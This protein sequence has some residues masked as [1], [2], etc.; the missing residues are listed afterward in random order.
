MG[1]V[2]LLMVLGA[3]DVASAVRR[4][5]FGGTARVRVAASVA[6]ADPVASR[7]FG[8]WLLVE[9]VHR[10]LYRLD[11]ADR[12]LPELL[13]RPCNRQVRGRRW[14]C[15]LR[16]G[17]RFHDGRVL[18]AADVRAAFL[19]AGNPSI[20][21]VKVVGART[22]VLT[23]ARSM[24]SRELA[25]LLASPRMVVPRPGAARVGLGAF[26]IDAFQPDLGSVTLSHAPDHYAGRPYLDGV[27]LTAGG[28][29]KAAIEAFHYRKADVV[30]VDSE[31]YEH[32]VRTVGP[33]RSTVGL[34]VFS[35]DGA[36]RAALFARAPTDGLAARVSGRTRPAERLVPHDDAPLSA[37]PRASSARS[38]QRWFVGVADELEAAGVWLAGGLSGGAAWPVQPLDATTLAAA[39]RG[40]SR[41]D[42]VLVSYEHVD[43][44][45]E[46]ALRSLA[47]WAKAKDPAR[48]IDGLP[49]IPLVDRARVLVTRKNLRDARW[50]NSGL[51]RLADAFIV[52]DGPTS[53][54]GR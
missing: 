45:A 7:S 46:D 37:R 48:L 19:R 4:P 27:T 3:V 36:A 32:A 29:A 38:P 18:R 15:V 22:V 8:D 41:F 24:K 54:G 2:V 14:K 21:R 9:W 23:T 10:G 1:W 16:E 6:T 34:R 43:P 25:R 12:A 33:V 31:R 40:G 42:A 5:D 53:A 50:T 52:T 13:E 26:R 51:L 44:D 47:R 30:F 39:L 11:H 20:S 17:L 49:W 28:G 35:G